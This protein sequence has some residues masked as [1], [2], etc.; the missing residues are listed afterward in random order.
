MTI[1]IRNDNNLI[2]HFTKPTGESILERAVQMRV[3]AFRA[4]MERGIFADVKAR[5]A[6]YPGVFTTR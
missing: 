1:T 2:T 3:T 5:A 4:D 6:R